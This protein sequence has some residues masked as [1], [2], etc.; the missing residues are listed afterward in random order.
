VVLATRA[1][2]RPG[3]LERLGHAGVTHGPIDSIQIES[4]WPLDHTALLE[5]AIVVVYA[6]EQTDD[7]R[8]AATVDSPPQ[9]RALLLAVHLALRGLTLPGPSRGPFVP[10]CDPR[11]L[12]SASFASAVGADSAD[13]Q[14]GP[15]RASRLPMLCANPGHSKV[16]E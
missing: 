11:G 5:Q 9:G 6:A 1:A 10:E 13:A 8:S 7:S 12:A 4:A 2:Q 14:R 15:F 16:G 3:L